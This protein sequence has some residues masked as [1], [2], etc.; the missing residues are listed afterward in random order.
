MN[1]IFDISN[2]HV[3][4]YV[5]FLDTKP[6]NIMPG[7]FTKIIYS[8]DCGSLN[9]LYIDC[10]LDLHIDPMLSNRSSVSAKYNTF[11]KSMS[12]PSLSTSHLPLTPNSPSIQ[13]TISS[14]DITHLS[15]N[16]TSASSSTFSASSSTLT[17]TLSDHTRNYVYFQSNQS[18]NAAIIQHCR[19]FEERLLSYYMK[20]MFCS[21]R[22]VFLLNNI[23]SSGSF[24]YY[25]DTGEYGLD[26]TR[27]YY[28]YTNAEKAIKTAKYVIKISGVWETIDTVG[29]T[30]KFL[31]M[32]V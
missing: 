31:R 18:Y 5:K 21:K 4:Q 26:Q 7:E 30:Y 6:N 23:L 22:P 13:N 16:S 3:E 29:L 15:T 14:V 27:D 20:Y 28:E 1:I 32:Y 17:A 8:N 11:T 9:G 19:T 2:I 25:C 10:P 12:A 24:K